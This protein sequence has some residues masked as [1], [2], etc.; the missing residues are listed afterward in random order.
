M[1]DAP[2]MNGQWFGKFGGS[3]P[4]FM[5]LN[6]DDVE[7][8][9]VGVAYLF[10]DDSTLPVTA[11]GF[12]LQEKKPT[13]E[14]RTT[15]IL[16]LDPSTVTPIPFEQVQP[17]F[18]KFSSSADI[19]GRLEDDSLHLAWKTDIG[20][21]GDCVISRSRAGEPSELQAQKMSWGD[22][23]DFVA[24]VQAERPVFRGQSSPWR[25]RTSYHR[26]GRAEMTR[27]V[28][29]DMPML[30]R[31]LSARTRHVFNI[32]GS[33]DENGAFLNLVQHHGY[34]TPLLDWTY[35]PYVAAFFA[36]RGISNRSAD[37]ADKDKRVRLFIF[38]AEKWKQK[39]QSFMQLI[40]PKLHITI[41][42][43]IAIENER[44][45][46]QQ[47]VTMVTNIDDVETYIRRKEEESG[48]KF[49]S[50]VD[51]PLS[52]R[53]MVVRELNYMGITAGSMFPGLDGACEELKERNFDF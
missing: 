25:L 3:T 22:F 1:N 15:Y 39:F 48:E 4:G 41:A 27:F 42:E 23:K 14:I 38:D 51:L 21:E 6:V 26:L 37:D 32:Q 19:S 34:S 13:F 47:A 35:S 18:G 12:L 16:P 49:L 31:N 40:C 2:R 52:E 17:R 44:L 30:H 53:R 20:I 43:F 46:P 45:I 36:Y 11:A 29:R 10:N 5:V 28:E 33:P 7:S 9:Y 8:G 50:A 24:H